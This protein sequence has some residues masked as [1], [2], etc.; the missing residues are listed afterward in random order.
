MAG[1]KR[2]SGANIFKG[3]IR[4]CDRLRSWNGVGFVYDL[5]TSVYHIEHMLE[6]YHGG[7][8]NSLFNKFSVLYSVFSKIFVKSVRL[9][10]MH[11]S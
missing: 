6:G 7:I 8:P 10:K 11:Q 4:S 5:K 9:R 2:T 3:K 1:G